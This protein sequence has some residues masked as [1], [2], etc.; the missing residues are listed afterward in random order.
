MLRERDSLHKIAFSHR[1]QLYQSQPCAQ[2]R[3]VKG[4]TQCG[5]LGSSRSSPPLLP[6]HGQG[7]CALTKSHDAC[8]IPDHWLFPT[9][10][11]AR[12]SLSHHHYHQVQRLFSSSSS[13]FSQHKHSLLVIFF[14]KLS[15]KMSVGWTMPPIPAPLLLPEELLVPGPVPWQLNLFQLLQYLPPCRESSNRKQALSSAPPYDCLPAS[16]PG[17]NSCNL[18]KPCQ[19][20]NRISRLPCPSR[21]SYF[22]LHLHTRCHMGQSFAK[23]SSQFPC[24]PTFSIS[25]RFYKN[26]NLCLFPHTS[27]V[28][29]SSPESYLSFNSPRSLYWRLSFS[30]VS[31]TF[32]I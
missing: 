16:P 32:K 8:W 19:W 31:Y 6:L 20:S 22:I 2:S 4:T 10:V 30:G 24:H 11:L 27:H 3:T 5:N 18:W 17:I 25:S 26:R 14:L 15:M 28:H 21:A 9:T 29:S 1:L 23:H 12:R 13:M 7:G